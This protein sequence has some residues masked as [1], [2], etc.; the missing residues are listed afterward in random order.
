MNSTSTGERSRSSSRSRRRVALGG[1]AA[2]ALG[3][4]LTLPSALAAGVG[5]H[6]LDGNILDDSA[7]ADP[8]FDWSDIFSAAT[9][10]AE[11]T[12]N[13]G[14]PASILE[15]DFARDFLVT[16]G[17]Y[18]NGDTSYYATGSK[19]TLNI[20]PGWQCKK[21]NNA[22]DKGDFVNAYGYAALVDHDG[23]STT[24]PHTVYFFGLE[25]DDDNGTNNVGIWLLQ[26]P[27]V[28]CTA[29]SGNTSFTGVHEDG[30]LLAV[31]SYDSGGS[32]GTAKGYSWNGG[33]PNDPDFTST[34]A[35]CDPANIDYT[36]TFCV[37]T[38]GGGT[39]DSPWWSPQKNNKL[40]TADLQKNVFVEGFL[41]ITQ[42]FDDLNEPQPC[43]ASALADTRSSTSTTATLYDYV[44]IESPT[45]GPMTIRKY[46]DR[47]ADG[48]KQTTEP[49]L[50]G[51]AYKV[52]KDGLGPTGTADFS[53]STAGT[54]PKLEFQDVPNGPYDVYET[55]QAGYY[56]TDP[57]T[58][59]ASPKKDV[60]Q[61]ASG[62]TV[63]FGNA[64]LINKKIT[65]AQVPTGA[66]LSVTYAINDPDDNGPSTTV[67][68]TVDPD[69]AT[70]RTVTISGLK[71]SDTLDWSYAYTSGSPSG[72]VSG[73]DDEAMN[74][75]IVET[76]TATGFTCRKDNNRTFPL[77]DLSGE[78]YKD[79]D[80]DGVLDTGTGGDTKLGG[81]EFKLYAGSGGAVGTVLGTATSATGTGAFTFTDV[82]PG[83]YSVVET[84][85]TGWRKMA[86]ATH[87]TV[88]VSLGQE[89]VDV[90]DFL[91]A[92]LT[93]LSVTVTPQTTSTYADSIQCRKT[94]TTTPPVGTD[95]D[96]L[97]GD[98]AAKTLTAT[99]L[100]VGS[101]TCTIVITD[102]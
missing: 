26:D 41:D 5:F 43:F 46:F 92:P 88:T 37:I 13:S 7:S 45:C 73:A 32:V 78:K 68:M 102:P 62:S 74:T 100:L 27:S 65:V 30:D 54:D 28:G 22:T 35:K 40:P 101:Y 82:A 16:N 49:W 2:L 81:F 58:A 29:G 99:D 76:A 97:P 83:T 59:A 57:N 44:E 31:V 6:E 91:N 38:N 9:P 39:I 11:P 1:I 55:M 3:V 4:G 75:G 25:K 72:S 60:N 42:F 93:N 94:G 15:P 67:A 80:A 77:A 96:A 17:A 34:D 84:G 48:Q 23:N 53:G 33:L 12:V 70:S 47:N 98:S 66:N 69:V 79:V 24:D 86:P 21:T 10:T 52:F 63:I 51:W 90:G 61:T 95:V 18:V 71:H 89:T 85:K 14:L 20:T 19:D 36:K 50:P 64:C 56:S 87:L 8:P